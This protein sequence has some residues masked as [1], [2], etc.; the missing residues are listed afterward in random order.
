MNKLAKVASF[1]LLLL[2]FG[3]VQAHADSIYDVIGTLTIPGNSSNPSVS[4]TINYSFMLDYTRLDNNLM[5]TF[6]G[7]P[8]VTSFGPLGTF[9]IRNNSS[10]QYIGFFSS[11][12]EIDLLGDFSPTFSPTPVLAGQAWLY[13]CTNMPTGPCARFFIGTGMNIYGTASASMHTVATPEPGTLYLS[14]LGVLALF[15]IKKD[16]HA[17]SRARRITKKGLLTRSGREP[18]RH[19]SCR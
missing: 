7:T 5:A 19:R 18:Q 17:L 4:E 2:A 16:S 13:N 1:L 14:A 3:A 12:A 8:T 9:A 10:Q 15:L 11:V 6:V